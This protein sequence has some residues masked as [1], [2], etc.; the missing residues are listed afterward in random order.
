MRVVFFCGRGWERGERWE[1]EYE[2]QGW[3]GILGEKLGGTP[4]CRRGCELCGQEWEGYVFELGE[5]GGG[6]G[7]LGILIY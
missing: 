1:Q 2:L 7:R 3:G 5:G 6:I 4:R